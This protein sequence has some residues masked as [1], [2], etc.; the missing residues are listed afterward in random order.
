MHDPSDTLGDRV[1]APERTDPPLYPVAAGIDETAR[2]EGLELPRRPGAG[3]RGVLLVDDPQGF[4]YIFDADDDARV[5]RGRAMRHIAGATTDLDYPADG[6][7]HVV[8][9][10]YESEYDVIAAPWVGAPPGEPPATASAPS[11]SK[12]TRGAR[13]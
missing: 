3:R 13:S 4:A 6:S 2:C 10:A 11:K 8:R 7:D 5:F 12:R 1:E 9:A